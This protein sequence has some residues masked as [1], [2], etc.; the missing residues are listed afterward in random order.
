MPHLSES[1]HNHV[2]AVVANPTVPLVATTN[3]P[4]AQHGGENCLHCNITNHFAKV[5]RKAKLNPD[6]ANALIAQA[7]YD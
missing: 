5:C 2:L 4:S 3:Q 7:Q 6:S 1:P